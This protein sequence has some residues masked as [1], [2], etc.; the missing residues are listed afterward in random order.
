M[1]ERVTSQPTDRNSTRM[2]YY[3]NGWKGVNQGYFL[4]N[5][6]TTLLRLRGQ[7]TTSVQTGP[8]LLKACGYDSGANAVYSD[9]GVRCTCIFSCLVIDGVSLVPRIPSSNLK[10]CLI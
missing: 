1:V 5:L 6:N 9:C 4:S 10:L 8:C 2:G 7:L 3:C